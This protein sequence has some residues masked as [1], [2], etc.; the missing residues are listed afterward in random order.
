MD[1]NQPSVP[2]KPTKPRTAAPKKKAK[3]IENPPDPEFKGNGA[4]LNEQ[5]ELDRA[6]SEDL[7]LSSQDLPSDL[8]SS[9][10]DNGQ[11]A[12]LD[13]KRTSSQP[14]IESL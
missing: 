2:T 1:Q 4:K 3:P 10:E 5:S 6:E 11:S 12:N 13:R 9:N 7:L 14:P 8:H